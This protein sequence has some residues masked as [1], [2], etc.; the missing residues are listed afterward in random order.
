M[1]GSGVLINAA[2]IS[3]G[4]A[5]DWR[6]TGAADMNNDGN[7][8]LL[9]QNTLGQIIVWYMDGSGALINAAWISIGATGDLR[10]R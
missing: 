4:A 10:V 7:A 2:W 3:I 5:G 9:F 8:D 6:V 1:N